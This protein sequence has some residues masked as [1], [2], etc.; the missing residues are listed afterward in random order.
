MAVMFNRDHPDATLIGLGRINGIGWL[1][2]LFK[3]V[4]IPVVVADEVLTGGFPVEEART[5][6]ALE[7]GWLANAT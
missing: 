3:E 2:E 5:T 4:L 6:A 1:Q 7:A